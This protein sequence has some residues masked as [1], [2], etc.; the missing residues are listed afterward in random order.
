[1][2]NNGHREI[3]LI[4]KSFPPFKGGISH[5]LY[6]IFLHVS[7]SF[8]VTVSTNTKAAVEDDYDYSS[9][10]RIVRSSFS[11]DKKWFYR[12]PFYSNSFNAYFK[13]NN[14]ITDIFAESAFPSGVICYILKIF[15]PKIKFHIFTYGSELFVSKFWFRSG[16]KAILM[17]ADNIIAIS[18]FTASRVKEITGKSPVIIFP[19]YDG[20]FFEERIHLQ[21]DEF[22]LITVSKLTERKGH[23]YTLKAL[24]ELKNK[25]KFKYFIVGKGPYEEE[26]RKEIEIS[27]LNENVE[28]ITDAD[29]AMLFELYRKASVFV[30]PTYKAGHDVE[31]FGIVYL[32]ACSHK[33]PII[34]T[35]SG[36][37]S[38][39]VKN[40][41]NGIFVREK[42]TEDI[43]NAL[44]ELYED[45]KKRNEFGRN[46]IAVAKNF[47]YHESAEK[48]IKS[49][50]SSGRPQ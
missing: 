29:N 27:G 8:K 46:G 26:I 41:F 32:E 30:M 18:N 17:K 44:I 3:L 1:M 31:G 5:Y 15:N 22:T 2:K 9:F 7:K 6:G 11:I 49:V 33:L 36:G 48:L 47:N 35:D 43:K 14:F 23:I 4:T 38:D 13:R 25:I 10:F 12:V 34:A 21:S 24:H 16:V 45:V 50:L 37:V 28:I 42:N 19:G 40:G 39:I 20:N